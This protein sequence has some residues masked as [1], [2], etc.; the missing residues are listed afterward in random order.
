MARVFEITIKPEDEKPQVISLHTLRKAFINHPEEMA[1]L[2]AEVLNSFYD[3]FE[4]GTATGKECQ[5]PVH[6]ST[7]R[8]IV[9]FVL[10]VLTGISEQ[11]HTDP[12]NEDAI[13]CAKVIRK[14]I[15][16]GNFYFGGRI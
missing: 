13:Y 15:E 4:F 12:R 6:R 8:S 7:Q 9:A 2:L 16:S 11:D 14:G 3:P 1:A 10:G 5:D